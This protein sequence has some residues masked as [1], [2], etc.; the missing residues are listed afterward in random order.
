MQLLP[1]SGDSETDIEEIV[2][3]ADPMR[4]KCREEEIVCGRTF[5][6]CFKC[7]RVVSSQGNKLRG[8]LGR[9]YPKEVLLH[10][11]E[12]N[13]QVR[14]SYP[15]VQCKVVD[16]DPMVVG[17]DDGMQIVRDLFTGLEKL[18]LGDTTYL[19]VYRRALFNGNGVKLLNEARNYFFLTPWL[20]LNERNY[21]KYQRT[22][23]ILKRKKLLEDILVANIISMSKGLGYTVP[24]LIEAKIQKYEEVH[25]SLKGNPMLGFLG[26]FVVN[27]EIPDYLGIG[28][29]VSRGFGTVKKI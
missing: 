19:I 24:G 25:T 27:F 3:V 1:K 14:Y 20:A 28:K 18:E 13:K 2:P 5:V 17:I 10:H 23:S 6:A 7:D 15:L 16:G 9:L 4:H 11:H 8:F 22:G 21:Q 12:K 26:K 29:S